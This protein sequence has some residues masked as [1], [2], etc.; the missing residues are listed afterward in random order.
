MDTLHRFR[1]CF[2]ERNQRTPEGQRIY[3]DHFTG[4]KSW[5]SD[6]SDTEKDAFEAELTFHHPNQQGARLFC[7]WHG[8]VKSPQLRIHFSWPIPGGAPLYVVYVGPK[9]TR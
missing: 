8:K 4:N 1:T 6:S 3:Q 5:F 2:D 7:A 9:I